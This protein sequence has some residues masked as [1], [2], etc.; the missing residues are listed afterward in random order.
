M[1]LSLSSSSG[2]EERDWLLVSMHVTLSVFYATLSAISC[3]SMVKRCRRRHATSS[4]KNKWQIWFHVI[5]ILG[6]W[7]RSIYFALVC[8]KTDIIPKAV[9]SFLNYFPSYLYFSCYFI[10][11]ICWAE[12][13]HSK[14]SSSSRLTF[15]VLQI[16]LITVNCCLYLFLVSIA[17]AYI[18][19]YLSDGVIS[20]TL[21]FVL[22]LV[23]ISVY[24]LLAFGFLLYGCLIL[25]KLVSQ[26]NIGVSP[27]ARAVL[28]RVIGLT[29]M[30]TCCFVTR[31]ILMIVT[32]NITV[33][34]SYWWADI[35]YYLGLEILPLIL[36]LVLL[37]VQ[38]TQK[39]KK[40]PIEIDDTLKQPLMN[41]DN[42]Q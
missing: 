27:T 2:A 15:R 18:G 38:S 21:N 3:W 1:A 7:T 39:Q 31:A 14:L 34:E 23:T 40:P 35:T 17:F 8:A 20:G 26:H 4:M 41:P 33:S 24:F 25:H 29:L 36:M 6:C 22:I 37:R 42:I 30:C 19:E 28:P 5:F 32:I 13:Y 12:I 10:V 9:D 16:I 11:I